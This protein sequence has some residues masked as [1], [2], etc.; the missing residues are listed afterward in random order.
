MALTAHS[1]SVAAPFDPYLAGQELPIVQPGEEKVGVLQGDLLDS[2]ARLQRGLF[3]IK[4]FAEETKNAIGDAQRSGNPVVVETAEAMIGTY[5]AI[6]QSAKLFGEML[7][8]KIRLTFC[9]PPE[10]QVGIRQGLEVVTYVGDPK[11]GDKIPIEFLSL[12]TIPA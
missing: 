4:Y 8:R 10:V 5:N 7:E 12:E 6:N 9:I 2:W 3:Y 11:P 1:K